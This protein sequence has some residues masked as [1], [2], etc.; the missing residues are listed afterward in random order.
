MFENRETFCHVCSRLASVAVQVNKRSVVHSLMLSRTH[1]VLFSRPFSRLRSGYDTPDW[2]R[3]TSKL[4]GII[5][6][7]AYTERIPFLSRNQQH[8]SAECI[9]IHLFVHLHRTPY[10]KS[11][12][13]SNSA[14]NPNGSH[15]SLVHKHCIRI[16]MIQ[17]LRIFSQRHRGTV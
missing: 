16:H 3:P 8:R 13:V 15:S 5:V 9:V 1:S 2:A 17:T 11:G 10:I 14:S 6:S 12:C 7:L 4:L